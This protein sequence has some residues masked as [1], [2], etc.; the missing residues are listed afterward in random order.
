MVWLLGPLVAASLVASVERK[1]H[2]RRR[3][4]RAGHRGRTGALAEALLARGWRVFACLRD[5]AG[6]GPQHRSGELRLCQLDQADE[7][8]IAR[9]TE[10]LSGERI[11]LLIHNAAIHGDAGGLATFSQ[12]DFLQV[13]TVNVAG[14]L[15]LTRVLLPLLS[16]TATVAFIS[17]RA[18]S[19][20]EGADLE[21]DYSY[22]PRRRH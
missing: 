6:A 10:E 11:D 22:W 16:A 18:G 17:S 12:T 8:S 19:M 20:A 15:L 21:G 2:V 1:Y 9:L 3:Q 14:P 13:M 5:P 7:A 4:V